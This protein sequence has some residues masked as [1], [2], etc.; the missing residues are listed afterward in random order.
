MPDPLVGLDAAALVGRDAEAIE[1]EGLLREHRLVAVVGPGGVGK[2]ALA[3]DVAR[4]MLPGPWAAVAATDLAGLET[5]GQVSHWM[6]CALRLRGRP[7]LAEAV[8]ERPTLLVV[9]TCEHLAEE[10]A[11]VL[12]RL[13]N[14]CAGMHV[15]LTSRVPLR[16]PA[17]YPLRPLDPEAAAT[18]FSR[19]ARRFGA[20][21][22]PESE[23]ARRICISLDGLPLAVQLAAGG[24]AHRTPDELLPFVSRL[25]HVLD[26]TSPVTA[27]PSRQRT[28]RASLSWSHRLCTPDERLLWARC[29]V[30]TD[31]FTLRDALAVCSDEWLAAGPLVTAFAGLAAQSVLTPEPPPHTASFRMPRVTR[32]YGRQRLE[33]L[34]EEDEFER[35][36][37]AWCVNSC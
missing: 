20:S 22:T 16:T 9:D 8:G 25:R 28:L 4:R 5:P 36:C 2:S 32:A 10:C 6:A 29:S 35:R 23:L 37:G 18:L 26:L 27:L 12:V 34:G 24:L 3:A 21:V 17:S 19:T 30:F 13:V 15:L 14:A 1:V 7:R 33:L 31:P 11:D